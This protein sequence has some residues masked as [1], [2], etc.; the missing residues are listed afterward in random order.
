MAADLAREFLERFMGW[1][2]L[3]GVML[4]CAALAAG[5]KER[6]GRQLF[7]DKRLSANDSVSCATCHRPDRAFTDGLPVARG[8][9][10]KLGSRNT[11]TLFNLRKAKRFFWDGSAWSLEQQA[12]GPLLNPLEMGNTRGGLEEK[13]NSI[14]EYAAAFRRVFGVPVVR[15]EQ[16]KQAL[17]AF[18]RTL[19]SEASLYDDWA[20]GRRERWTPTHERGRQLFAK[21]A[22]CARCHPAPHFTNGELIASGEGPSFKVPTLRE[23]ARTAPYFHDGRYA[24]LDEVLARH[25]GAQALDAA[26]RHSLL[27]FLLS[28][29]GDST[30]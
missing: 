28:L 16:V 12:E 14:P 4:S 22:G 23:L 2:L 18:E 19:V 8:I 20:R 13:L 27:T 25:G 26:A 9:D 30:R 1:H 29:S 11:P 10:G 3:L 15:L 17:A 24:T 5:E 6:L 21:T 7:F